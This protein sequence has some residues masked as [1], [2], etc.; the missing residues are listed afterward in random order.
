M[1]I[2]EL[3]S[4]SEDTIVLEVK[5]KDLETVALHPYIHIDYKY[6]TLSIKE[7]RSGSYQFTITVIKKD[8]VQFSFEWGISYVERVG[9]TLCML[10]SAV[11]EFVKE[12]DLISEDV[13]RWIGR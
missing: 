13:K 2:F 7:Q 9:S 5:A 6:I 11:I 8:G 4:W 10:R 3:F 12:K 1:E